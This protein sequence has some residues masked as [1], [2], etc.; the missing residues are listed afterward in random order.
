MNAQRAIYDSLVCVNAQRA[1]YDSLV[2][3]NMHI[4][5]RLVI[6]ICAIYDSS[7][8]LYLLQECSKQQ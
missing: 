8:F 5:M 1:I 2:C 3:V 6:E 4:G 7:T